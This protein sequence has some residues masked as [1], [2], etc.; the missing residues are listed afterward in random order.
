MKK[1][2]IAAG[3]VGMAA[4]GLTISA[5]VDPGKGAP[6]GRMIDVGGHALHIACSGD[7]SLRPTVVIDAGAGV[8]SPGYYWVQQGVAG[9]TRVCA[10]DR[11]GMGWSEPSSASRDAVTI[12]RELHTLLQNAGEAGPYIVAGHSIGGLM[13]PIFAKLY[14]DETAGLVFIDTS[15][16][17]QNLET[18]PLG[19]AFLKGMEVASTIGLAPLVRKLMP[20]NQDLPRPIAI[21]LSR[22]SAAPG[23]F[24]TMAREVKAFHTSASEARKVTDLGD[25]PLIV[26]SAAAT[27]FSQGDPELQ[28][29]VEIIETKNALQKRTASLST[30]GRQI[31][32][33]QA[34][35]MSIVMNKQH[36]A[37]VVNAVRE[38]MAAGS[39]QRV[40]GEN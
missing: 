36:A 38:V 39:A 25:L 6:P 15:H 18:P 13:M 5:A 35:H 12:A 17:D 34:D 8:A 29:E 14:P 1:R 23:T 28:K 4:L 31:I 20:L 7:Q 9:F 11:A 3:I 40:D 2:W 19:F 21:S 22:L 24:S 27:H 10:Y 26:L 37:H 32:L 16:P 33:P 30:R